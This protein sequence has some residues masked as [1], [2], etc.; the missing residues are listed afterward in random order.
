[1]VEVIDVTAGLGLTETVMV[2]GVLV[3]VPEITDLGVTSYM[4]VCTA[5]VLLI[6]V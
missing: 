1:M 3:Q 4:T 2:N 5:L 6:S